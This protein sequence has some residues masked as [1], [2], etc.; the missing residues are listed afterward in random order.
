MMT[1]YWAPKSRSLRALWLMEEAG[2][3]YERVL[4][5]IRAGAQATPEFRA[6][7][8]MMKVPALADGAAVVAEP[9]AIFAYVA[10]RVPEAGLAP[11]LGDPARGRYLQWLFF[12]AGCTEAAYIQKMTGLQINASTAGWGDF[13]RVMGVIEAALAPGPWLLGER[14]SAADIMLGSDLHF[15]INV[16]KIVEARPAFASYLAR[17]AA[18]PA[19]QR[20]LA[21]DAGG[22]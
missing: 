13:D 8:P 17:C 5:D 12:A 11:P 3:P 18:R 19:F 20:A 14:F 2:R 22:A 1:L 4:I 21:I 9:G 16:F 7:N 6:I 10:E 15:G